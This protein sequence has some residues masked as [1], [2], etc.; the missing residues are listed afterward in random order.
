MR[1][2]AKIVFISFDYDNDSKH[3]NLLLA[4]NAHKDFDFKFY[5]GSLKAAINSEDAKYMKSQLRPM[6]QE[7]THV[8][9]IVG[10]ESGVTAHVRW[11]A[12]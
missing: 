7:A 2:A 9:C 6:I 8:L 12:C 3:K 5:D 1:M 11:L 10:S 4:W